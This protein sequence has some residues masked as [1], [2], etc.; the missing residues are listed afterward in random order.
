MTGPFAH[1]RRAGARRIGALR[2][3]DGVA[4]RDAVDFARS[5]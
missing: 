3:R 4:E 2:D 1:P 5:R